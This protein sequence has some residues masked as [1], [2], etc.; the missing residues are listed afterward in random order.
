MGEVREFRIRVGRE[1]VDDLRERLGRT[2]WGP[3]EPEV[4]WERGVPVSYLKR[5]VGYWADGFNWTAAEVRLNRM[6]QFVTEIDGQT[7]HFVHR[8]SERAGAVPL[9]LVHGWPGSFVEFT[10][11]LPQLTDAFHLVVPDVP[12][13]GYSGPLRETGWTT[14]RIA[15]TFLELMTRLGHAEF[16]VQGGRSGARIAAEMGRRAPGRV[17]GVH[18]NGLVTPPADEP[19]AMAGLT[20][21]EK[22]R[23]ARLAEF[24]SEGYGF[25]AL[26]QTRP[27][28]LGHALLDSPAGQLAWT[29]EKLWAWTDARS[30]LPEDAVDRDLLLADASLLWFT[31]TAASAAA[32]YYEDAH[33]PGEVPPR[34]RGPVPTAVLATGTTDVA[35]RRFADRE[36]NV[37]RWTELERGGA[38]LALEQPAAFAEDV[39]DFF[40]AVRTGRFLG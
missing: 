23:L 22:E 38:F 7:V 4:G 9:L 25:A 35:V 11:V 20:E 31:R 16:G 34:P 27:A 21:V 10:E 32:L 12:G 18:L 2:R 40:A 33:D 8:P 26:Q 17:I 29:V 14:G 30:A 1:E 39:R 19:T 28:T 3:E 5:L 37:T 13:V 24:H 15:D 36:H 6:P